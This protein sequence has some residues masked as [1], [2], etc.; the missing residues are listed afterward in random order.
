MPLPLRDTS[1]RPGKG[2]QPASLKDG[3]DDAGLT[4]SSRIEATRKRHFQGQVEPEQASGQK[5]WYRGEYEVR[6]PDPQAETED[7]E[8]LADFV[9]VSGEEMPRGSS[10]CAEDCAS[11]I[12]VRHIDC[13]A[14]KVEQ[15]IITRSHGGRSVRHVWPQEEGQLRNGDHGELCGSKLGILKLVGLESGRYT[16]KLSL[17][18][19]RDGRA[20]AAS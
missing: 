5:L 8:H 4:K 6:S 20:E 13:P 7:P 12:P 17:D 16:S 1:L 3:Q 15:R 9:A 11:D 14:I 2:G 19:A 10:R 18:L